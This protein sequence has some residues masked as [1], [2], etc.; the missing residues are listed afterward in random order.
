M[1]SFLALLRNIATS[2]YCSNEGLR[3][4]GNVNQQQDNL[5]RKENSWNDH[6]LANTH[7]KNEMI[8]KKEDLREDEQEMLTRVGLLISM[9]GPQ[10]L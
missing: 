5:R 9:K 4:R 1:E 7:Y 3:Y 2:F 6:F 8:N 10:I